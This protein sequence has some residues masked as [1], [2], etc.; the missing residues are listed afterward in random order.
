LQTQ[1][2]PA[3][4]RPLPDLPLL[5][6]IC[7]YSD[8]T[9]NGG[10]LATVNVALLWTY[11]Q[12]IYRRLCKCGLLLYIANHHCF[13]LQKFLNL[14]QCFYGFFLLFPT[15]IYP[16]SSTEYSF[17]KEKLRDISYALKKNNSNI[18]IQFLF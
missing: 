11:L 13:M 1:H 4:C 12:Q 15:H 10:Q 17:G 16:K 8:D 9:C 2:S 18:N 3:N 6:L 7:G 5:K 14:L